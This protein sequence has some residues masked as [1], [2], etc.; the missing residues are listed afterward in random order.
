MLY[1]RIMGGNRSFESKLLSLFDSV[2]GRQNLD[3]RIPTRI[4][5]PWAFTTINSHFYL[6]T[7]KFG[8]DLCSIF[9]VL[10]YFYNYVHLICPVVCNMKIVKHNL[11]ASVLKTRR[12]NFHFILCN[13][14]ILSGVQYLHWWLLCLHNQNANRPPNGLLPW[15]YHLCDLHVSALVSQQFFFS[16]SIC[17]HCNISCFS[18]LCSH[19]NILK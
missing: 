17:Y 9:E 6:R 14:N 10:K 5:V 13:L 15:W 19:Y 16:H 12:K 18:L 11:L 8:C 2:F 3:L 4:S 1:Q 7:M